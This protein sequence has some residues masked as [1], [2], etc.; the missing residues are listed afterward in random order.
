MP[1]GLISETP[2]YGGS[3]GRPVADDFEYTSDKNDRWAD[4][5]QL[6]DMIG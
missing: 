2:E 3:K 6:L 5:Q 1:V 4:R